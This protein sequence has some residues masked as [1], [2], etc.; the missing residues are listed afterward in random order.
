ME[1]YVEVKLIESKT[2][3]K[4]MAEVTL[5]KKPDIE[6]DRAVLEI[7]E[8]SYGIFGKDGKLLFQPSDFGEIDCNIV[9]Y[10]DGN[11]E[12]VFL[13]MDILDLN[14]SSWFAAAHPDLGHPLMIA[15][16]GK[17][18]ELFSRDRARGNNDICFR[19]VVRVPA[20]EELTIYHVVT[21]Q[22]DPRA[23]YNQMLDVH[24]RGADYK[25]RENLYTPPDEAM[26]HI[27]GEQEKGLFAPVTLGHGIHVLY[28]VP[29]CQHDMSSLVVSGMCQQTIEEGEG[30][31][32]FSFS[33][34]F[35]TIL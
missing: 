21:K 2:D 8:Q 30:K 6:Y 5:I 32:S 14:I 9:F 13:A 26:F 1:K 4:V 7:D 34:F 12:Y 15:E 25:D 29:S 33:G 35:K 28:V 24:Y 22:T 27:D 10:K 3:E 31:F 20:D 18:M 11:D 16:N 19:M 23:K 17:N